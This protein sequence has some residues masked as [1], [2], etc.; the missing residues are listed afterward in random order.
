ME[1]LPRRLPA[2]KLRGRLELRRSEFASSAFFG[3]EIFSASAFRSHPTSGCD[4]F[5]E[6][7]ETTKR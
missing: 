5:G 4:F 2:L 6:R 1:D 3:G 7:M